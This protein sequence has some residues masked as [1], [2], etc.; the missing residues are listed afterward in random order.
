MSFNAISILDWSYTLKQCN[1]NEK[2]NDCILRNDPMVMRLKLSLCELF[3][4][5]HLFQ[6]YFH[7]EIKTQRKR[8][9]YIM[10]SDPCKEADSEPA[11]LNGSRFEL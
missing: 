11:C 3:T 6:N 9:W 7:I 8:H 5:I 10:D 4:S 1:R 2:H